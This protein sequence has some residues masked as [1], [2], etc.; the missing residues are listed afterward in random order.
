MCV[1]VQVAAAKCHMARVRD[2]RRVTCMQVPD[3]THP[4]YFP[5]MD[6]LVEL[7]TELLELQRS[8]APDLLKKL[9]SAPVIAQMAAGVWKLFWTKPLEEGSVDVNQEAVAVF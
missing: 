3:H 7:N 1:C 9:Q 2:L 5:T 4:E 8:D 6:R